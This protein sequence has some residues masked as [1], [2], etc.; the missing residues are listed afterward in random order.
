MR[1]QKQAVMAKECDAIA[2]NLMAQEGAEGSDLRVQS[3]TVIPTRKVVQLMDGTWN[4]VVTS[5]GKITTFLIRHRK[6]H[7]A[8]QCPLLSY[9]IRSVDVIAHHGQYDRP[10]HG[11]EA[12][13]RSGDESV[14]R[15]PAVAALSACA[16]HH[17]QRDY[18]L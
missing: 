12:D 15:R 17:L 1:R 10:D 6:D 9:E 2:G 16:A 7:V 3:V 4:A 5:G 11:Q 18:T 8:G 14:A 13:V